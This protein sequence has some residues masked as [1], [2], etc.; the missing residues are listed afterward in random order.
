[1]NEVYN[2]FS[3]PCVMYFYLKSICLFMNR[4]HI[5]GKLAQKLLSPTLF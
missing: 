4:D 5:Y 1:M 2:A 3:L